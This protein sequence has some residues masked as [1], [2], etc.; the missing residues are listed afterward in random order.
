MHVCCGEDGEGWDTGDVFVCGGE[1]Q[2]A[3][4]GGTASLE[5]SIFTK[6]SLVFKSCLVAPAPS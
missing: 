3:D 2:Y 6:Y 4:N 1:G 5:F